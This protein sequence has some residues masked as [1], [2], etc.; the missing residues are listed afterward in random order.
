MEK[1]RDTFDDM[2]RSKLQDFEVD[3]MPGGL[4]GYCRSF[5]GKSTGTFP[6]NASLLGCCGSYFIIDD[7]RR[8]LYV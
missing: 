2:F 6:S 4:G 3:T 1:E 7:N 5:T 8:R